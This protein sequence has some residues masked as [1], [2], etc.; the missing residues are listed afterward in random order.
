MKEWLELEEDE[1]WDPV[2]FDLEEAQALVRLV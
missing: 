2:A 1:E